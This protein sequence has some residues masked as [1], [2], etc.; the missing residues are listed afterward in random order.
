MLEHGEGQ[1]GAVSTA[2]AAVSTAGMRGAPLGYLCSYADVFFTLGIGWI[3][4]FKADPV[5]L[6]VC[7]LA[8]EAQIIPFDK[9]F[10]ETTNAN[11]DHWGSAKC[12]PEKVFLLV[13]GKTFF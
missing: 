10:S 6:A 1:D 4:F 12:D 2:G 13:E 5:P 3:S 8:F 11:K 9:I 7:L